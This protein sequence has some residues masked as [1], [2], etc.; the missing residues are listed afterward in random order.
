VRLAKGETRGGAIFAIAPPPPTEAVP[1]KLL[2]LA[3]GYRSPQLP[4]GVDLADNP[5]S[6]KMAYVKELTGQGVGRRGHFLSPQRLDREGRHP[7]H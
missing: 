5:S 7:R 4:L 2:L 1:F 3:H 6:L